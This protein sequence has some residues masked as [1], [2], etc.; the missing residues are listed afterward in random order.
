MIRFF[1]KLRWLIK[2]QEEIEKLLTKKETLIN[3]GTYSLIGVP[4]YQK[5]YIKELLSDKQ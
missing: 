2:H 4:E 1:R 5:E 3:D